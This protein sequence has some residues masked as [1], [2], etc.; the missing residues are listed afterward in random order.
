LRLQ[1]KTKQLQLLQLCFA[2]HMLLREQLI[3][4][5][6]LLQHHLLQPHQQEIRSCGC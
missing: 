3:P 4:G 6:L 1:L 5:H 2:L